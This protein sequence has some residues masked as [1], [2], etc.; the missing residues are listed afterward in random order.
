MVVAY[1]SDIEDYAMMLQKYN[2]EIIEYDKANY[3]DALIYK[4][5]TS[6]NII[7]ELHPKKP[8]L[9][10]D[11]TNISIEHAVHVLQTGI[12]SPLF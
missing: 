2:I 11:I 8:T 1:T 6:N 7:S 5:S 12:Y 3:F 10:L 9:F 4:R